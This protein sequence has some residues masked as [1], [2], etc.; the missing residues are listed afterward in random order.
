MYIYMYIHTCVCICVYIDLN[1]SC[2]SW[3]SHLLLCSCRRILVACIFQVHFHRKARVCPLGKAT[4]LHFH[5]SFAL[6]GIWFPKKHL[7]IYVCLRNGTQKPPR[8]TQC[9]RG[10]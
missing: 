5:K 7:G 8:V 4:P 10:V 2:N 9:M 3:Q 1:V 6:A